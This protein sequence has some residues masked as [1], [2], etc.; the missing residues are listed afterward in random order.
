MRGKLTNA[1]EITQIGASHLIRV[2]HWT[3]I[4]VQRTLLNLLLYLI[5]LF[6]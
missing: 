1:K 2:Y 4:E 6:M 5:N 3:K